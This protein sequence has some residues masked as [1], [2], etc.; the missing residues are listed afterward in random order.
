MHLH[1]DTTETKL[2]FD[3][4]RDKMAASAMSPVGAEKL[5]AMRPCATAD[6][7][8]SEMQR[9]GELL[10]ALRFDDPFPLAAFPDVRAVLRRVAPEGGYASVEDLADLR[11]VLGVAARVRAYLGTRQE[12][13]AALSKVAKNLVP[14]DALERHLDR[15]LDAEGRLRDDA[16]PEL[17]RLR[18]AIVQAQSR[19]RSQ[20][21]SALKQ[22]IEDGYA[23]DEQPTIRGGRMVI[24]VRAEARRRVQGFV[25]DTSATGQTVYVE[26]TSV[27]ELNNEVREMEA[28][29]AREI[30]RILKSVAAEIRQVRPD[31]EASTG[32][33][34]RLDVLHAKARLARALDAHAPEVTDDGI[35][36][37][38]DARHPLLALRFKDEK[39]TVVPLTLTLGGDFRT[40]VITGP[41]AGGKSVAM[42]SVGLLVLMVGY[43]IPIPADRASAVSFFDTLIV[44]IGDEQTIEED[45]S[46]F[47]SHVKTLKHL[48]ARADNRSLVLLDEAGTGTDPGEGGALAQAV[49]EHL[50]DVGAR[51]IATTHIGALKVFAH[52]RAGVENGAMLFDQDTLSPTYKL[53]TGVPGSSYA[54]EIA[55]R[56]GLDDA[57]LDRARALLGTRQTALEE[58]IVALEDARHAVE[59]ER[60]EA[61]AA[62]REAER[63]EARFRE[64]DEAMRTQRTTLK[65]Q[66]LD[67]AERIVKGANARVEQT[68]REIREAQAAK[69]ATKEARAGL[70][71]FAARVTEQQARTR[72][73][74]PRRAAEPRRDVIAVGDQVVIE[75]GTT[76]A[77]VL[78]IKGADAVIAQGAIKLRTPLAGLRKVGGKSPQKVVVKNSAAG[79]LT[80]LHARTRIDLRGQRVEDA[81]AEVDRLLDEALAAGV[82]HVEILHGKGTGA[83]RL[84]IRDHLK[85]RRDV[86]GFDDAPHEQG[87]PGRDARGTGVE[88]YEG[89]KMALET[90]ARTGVY[91][92]SVHFLFLCD[93]APLAH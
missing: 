55:G 34:V 64:R 12:K 50:T 44:D 60:A 26:P 13:Y 54:F 91:G 4:L 68:I 80:A 6:E 48:V 10:D 19:L 52:D 24:P 93:S 37:L 77:E 23:A 73:K 15:I 62:R 59:T 61:L 43:G 27:L 25:H 70:E 82:A 29:E 42:K 57:L 92:E 53:Q 78:E 38:R 67:E 88:R 7:A 51:T 8:R 36:A 20:L 83:L 16:S 2:G 39:R 11:R 66:A 33:L 30:E 85:A 76:A 65:Q 75:G 56:E 71:D 22:A 3:V 21:T 31:V 90:A 69:E 18:R 17:A 45:L 72:P 5:R 47:T 84:A 58:L 81:L 14:A 87:G 40:L 41:N 74:P 46:T 35:L 32:A 9:V 1:P 49:L 63:A 28:A 86:A 89:E 79:G